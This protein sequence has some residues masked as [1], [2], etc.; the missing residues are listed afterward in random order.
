MQMGEPC[1]SL[2]GDLKGLLCLHDILAD[3]LVV[4]ARGMVQT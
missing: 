2:T 4:G 3:A 1:A